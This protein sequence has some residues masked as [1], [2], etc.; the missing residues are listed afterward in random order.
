MLKKL[1]KKT[2]FYHIF[3]CWAW[4]SVAE[5]PAQF[6]DAACNVG[7]N[8]CDTDSRQQLVGRYF[9]CVLVS[10]AQMLHDSHESGCRS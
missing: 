10:I 8:L 1:N 9:L 7:V 4:K 6:K 2:H 5:L 3:I